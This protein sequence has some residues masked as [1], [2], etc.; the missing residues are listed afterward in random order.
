MGIL[1]DHRLVSGQSVTGI[2][3]EKEMVLELWK[4]LV[5]KA[6]LASSQQKQC[7]NICTVL[8]VH[9]ILKSQISFILGYSNVFPY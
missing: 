7:Y 6:F 5:R 4:L 8:C 9:E 1:D 2:Q 3:T